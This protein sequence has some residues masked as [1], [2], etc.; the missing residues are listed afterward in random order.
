MLPLLTP[1]P[2]I[3]KQCCPLGELET[4]ASLCLKAGIACRVTGPAADRTVFVH[5][6]QNSSNEHI[7]REPGA[8]G[9][10]FIKVSGKT[11]CRRALKAL[12]FL[13]Y[14]V[15][16]YAARESLRGLPE[17]RSALP[18][19]RP[20]KAHPLSGAERQRRFRGKAFQATPAR[21]SLSFGPSPG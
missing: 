9:P 3:V 6:V 18:V 19:G 1:Q 10:V 15:F 17:A 8:Y 5:A 21:R 7:E 11:S 12:G 2:T 14:V 4:V 16:D 13:A 20:R